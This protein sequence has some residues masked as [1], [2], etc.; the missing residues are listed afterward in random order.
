MGRR[1]VSSAR[2]AIRPSRGRTRARAI[3]KAEVVAHPGRELR[4]NPRFVITNLRH[5]PD[6]LYA[7]IYCARGDSENRLKELHHD[8]TFGRTS[9]S[10][11]WANQLRVTLT[12]AA[13]VL[14]QE[15]QL[16]G[17]RTPP[18]AG[19]RRARVAANRSASCKT[20]RQSTRPRNE[21]RANAFPTT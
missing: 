11:F 1:R 10:R 21:G 16:R 15:L 20:C 12:A 5:R 3:I 9:C 14:L 6:R 7:E 18:A 13:Y 2:P 19:A 8:L 17:D 4:D